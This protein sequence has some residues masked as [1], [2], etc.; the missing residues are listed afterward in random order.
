MYLLN[1]VYNKIKNQKTISVNSYYGVMFRKNRAASQ[2][3]NIAYQICLNSKQ[4]LVNY[5]TNAK[6]KPY[7]YMS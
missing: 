7:E 1:N 2:L 5:Y 3:R 4:L 6:L